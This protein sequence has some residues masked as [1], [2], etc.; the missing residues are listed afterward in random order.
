MKQIQKNQVT[1]MAFDI[2]TNQPGVKHGFSTKLGGVSTGVYESMNLGF[3]RGDSDDNV[4]ENYKRMAN[5]LDMSMDRMCLSHQTHTTNVAIIKESHAGNG[6]VR[7]NEFHDIDGMITNVKNLPLVT[8]YADC[9]PLFLYDPVKEVI[10][11]SHSGWR[12]TVGKIGKI[13][14]EKMNAE[15]GCQPTDILCAIGPSICK[16]CYEVSGDVADEFKKA[17][18]EKSKSLLRKSIFN[19]ADPDKYMLDLWEACK[20][21]FLEAG[22]PDTNIEVTDYC[23]HCNPNLFYSHRIMGPDRGSLAAFMSL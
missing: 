18:G 3:G 9:V 4:Y 21:N 22:V 12:G 11:L 17:F 20:L 6:I 2:F 5:A 7:P 8:F 10:G 19:P 15:F 1:F 23:T 16:D 13:T 14:V